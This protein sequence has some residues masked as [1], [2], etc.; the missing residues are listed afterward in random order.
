MPE[1]PEIVITQQY[2]TTKIVGKNIKSI[3][4]LSGRYTHQTMDGLDEIMNKYPL[5]V[6][7]VNSKGKFMWIEMES[8]KTKEIFY[9]MNTF[10]MTGSWGF[11]KS[12]SSRVQFKIGSKDGKVYNLYYDDQRNF[13]TIQITNNVDDLEKR[14]NKLAPDCLKTEMTD[15]I[16]VNL[17]QNYINNKRKKQ[18]NVVKV[19]MDDQSAIVSGI[20]NYLIAEILYD[21]KISP[22]SD[23]TNLT[24]TQLKKLAHSI[25]KIV[26]IA[27][28]DNGTGY[29]GNFPDFLKKH[30]ERIA[31]GKFPNY[32]RDIDV[33]DSFQFKVYGQKTDPLGNEV[34]N[35]EIIVGRTIHWVPT[36]QK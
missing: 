19:L 3:K 28:Y 22:F 2:L 13:G 16:L 4:I 32:H 6:K 31:N 20:G 7:S 8:E 35:D 23:L 29:M 33:P 18:M 5:R 21:A 10:G 14:L 11:Y 17:I 30:K 12:N 15:N 34:Q 25:R 24:G 36:V 27:Y 1:G 26:K 9:L